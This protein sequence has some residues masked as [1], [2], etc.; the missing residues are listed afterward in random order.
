VPPKPRRKQQQPDR[1]PLYDPA[2]HTDPQQL[3]FTELYCLC[4]SLWRQRDP[5][6][7]VAPRVAEF[8]ERHTGRSHGPASKAD[9][10]RARE[11]RREALC[12]AAGKPEQFRAKTYEHIDTND[13]EVWPWPRFP[14]PEPP[15]GHAGRIA[16]AKPRR[17]T[18]GQ[19]G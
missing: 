18:A 13:V 2:A 10:I 5:V 14:P 4:G 6:A 1:P 17:L 16:P 7:Y 3:V 9:C 11:A 8:I 15:A 12:M 19:E